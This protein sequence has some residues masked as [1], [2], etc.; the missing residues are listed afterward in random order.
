MKKSLLF[1]LLFTFVLLICTF[2]LV[3]PGFAQEFSAQIKIQQPEGTYLF[4]Y[5]VKD[6]LYR[7]EG[8]DSSGEPFV[9]IVN[10]KEDTY[11]GIH[12]I[13]KFYMEFSKEGMF[14]FSYS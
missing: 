12:P 5:F 7:L 10:R 2:L 1:S 6:H 8:K 4:N 11:I 3:L 14:L 9:L 13:M